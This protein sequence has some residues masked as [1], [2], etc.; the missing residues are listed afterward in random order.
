MGWHPMRSYYDPFCGERLW[1]GQEKDLFQEPLAG[2]LGPGA[3]G[4]R[5]ESFPMVLKAEAA[6]AS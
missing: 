1:Y 4:Y 5:F 6:A 2:T 3:L